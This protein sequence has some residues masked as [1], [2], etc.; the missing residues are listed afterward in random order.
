M[1]A[2]KVSFMVTI[3]GFVNILLIQFCLIRYQPIKTEFRNVNNISELTNII[4]NND[5][6]IVEIS[7]DTCSFVMTL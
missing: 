5:E 2:I 4:E 7:K 6:V 1:Y 3:I